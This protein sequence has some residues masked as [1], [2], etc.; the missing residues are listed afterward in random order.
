ML[1]SW[2]LFRLL[3]KLEWNLTLDEIWPLSGFIF[4]PLLFIIYIMNMK[5]FEGDLVLLFR[6][7]LWSG[8]VEVNEL[9][10]QFT[11]YIYVYHLYSR[12]THYN[13]TSL[14]KS[15][16]LSQCRLLSMVS[17]SRMQLLM[18]WYVILLSPCF[19]LLMDWAKE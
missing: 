5:I 8:T 3:F 9:Y 14:S 6:A 12:K 7:T 11:L 19:R 16:K 10:G 13:L 18:K 4:V 2:T 15:E 17:V 1:N